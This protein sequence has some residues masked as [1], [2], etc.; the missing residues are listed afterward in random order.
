MYFTNSEALGGKLK[1]RYWDF[2]VQEVYLEN[3]EKKIS[4]L[5]DFETLQKEYTKIPDNKDNLDF[6]YFD[7]QKINQ[8]LQ[9][10]IKSLALTMRCGKSRFGNAG[11][12]DKRAVTSQR[13]SIYQPDLE[14]LKKFGRSSI[15]LHNF[16]WHENKLDIGD[17]IGNKFIII[18]RD[19]NKTDDEIKQII[20]E[21]KT[22]VSNGIPNK[23]GEQRFGGIRDVTHE[24]GKLFVEGKTKE[25]VLHYLT[26][27]VDA[28]S[29]QVKEA[30][31]L[32]LDGKYKEALKKF[33]RDGY[34]YELAILDK[35]S[36]LENDFNGAW[37]QLPKAITYL[38][39]H[40]YQ[41]YLFNKYLDLRITE[42]GKKALDP[43]DGDILDED[44]NVLGPLFG[45]DF[46]LAEG[47]IGELEKRILDE[48]SL[49]LDLFKIKNFPQMSVSGTRR[50]IKLNVYDLELIEI[51]DDEFFENAKSVK[52]SFCLDKA[53]YATTVLEELLKG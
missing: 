4:E 19:V 40:A 45:Y 44:G 49:T 21:F 16:R 41:S 26:K 25:A 32:V 20:D 2:I 8:D 31:Q 12:K 52:L 53:N 47:K 30:R 29:E 48:D 18:I 50:A 42:F 9:N 43:Q 27:T 22:Q 5:V 11:L 14:L 3:D 39:T 7:M 1:Y 15:K 24:V 35:L 33:P 46:K 38:F 28:E 10:V 36:K 6:L 34:R 13:L 51:S 17:L 23:F 37:M